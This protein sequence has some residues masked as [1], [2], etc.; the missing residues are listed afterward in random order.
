MQHPLE[1][2]ATVASVRK[3]MHGVIAMNHE[4]QYGDGLDD[5]AGDGVGKTLVAPEGCGVVATRRARARK[6]RR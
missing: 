5:G 6:S 2:A 1:G 4:M 3:F